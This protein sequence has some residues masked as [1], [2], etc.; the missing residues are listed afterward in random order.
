M[1]DGK[2]TRVS[3]DLCEDGT[4]LGVNFT[5]LH[6][7]FMSHNVEISPGFHSVV[8][9]LSLQY[10]NEVTS[11][12]SQMLLLTA[13]LMLLLPEDEHSPLLPVQT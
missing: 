3:R 8:T 6:L 5:L 12:S 1:W 11:Q 10:V 4:P 2:C 7:F 9:W 13:A